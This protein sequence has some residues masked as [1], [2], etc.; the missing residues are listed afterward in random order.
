MF[1]SAIHIHGVLH[2]GAGNKPLTRRRDAHWD[3]RAP[4]ACR[5][6]CHGGDGPCRAACHGADLAW[7]RLRARATGITAPLDQ[8]VVEDTGVTKCDGG[9]VKVETSASSCQGAACVAIRC[10]THARAA[11]R[12]SQRRARNL[13]HHTHKGGSADRADTRS[14]GA[15][16]RLHT[17]VHTNKLMPAAADDQF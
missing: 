3:S 5:L 8:Q 11:A 2:H 14:C 9:V 7:Q 10:A 6:A 12:R 4:A 16:N 13:E 17:G 1:S 15:Q